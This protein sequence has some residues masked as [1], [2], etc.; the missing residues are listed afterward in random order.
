VRA[1]LDGGG[2]PDA[3][4]HFIA[5]LSE[6]TPLEATRLDGRWIDIGSADDLARANAG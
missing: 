3:P 6:R 4:G 1:Y 2:N 5:W